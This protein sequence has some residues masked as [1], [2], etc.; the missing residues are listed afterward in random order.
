MEG[1]WSWSDALPLTKPNQTKPEKS[2]NEVCGEDQIHPKSYMT[3]Y[4]FSS[5]FLLFLSH[6]VENGVISLARMA[7]IFYI[8]IELLGFICALYSFTGFIIY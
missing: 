3:A 5:L 7:I 2:L 1:F 4:T 6:L 8:K